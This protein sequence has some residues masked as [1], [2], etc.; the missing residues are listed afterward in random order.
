[1]IVYEGYVWF[2]FGWYEYDWWDVDYYNKKENRYDVVFCDIVMLRYV[3]DGY[4]MLS[5]AFLGLIKFLVIGNF[6]VG[7]YK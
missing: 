2:F 4:F 5:K 6:I 1:M 7:R 3:V